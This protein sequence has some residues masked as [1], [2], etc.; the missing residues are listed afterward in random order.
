[1]GKPGGKRPLVR[2]TRRWEDNIKIDVEE[3]GCRVDYIDVAYDMERWLPFVN[4]VMNFWA[5]CK[6]MHLET[7]WGNF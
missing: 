4:A 7:S 5:P 3:M 2:P 1:M 6:E